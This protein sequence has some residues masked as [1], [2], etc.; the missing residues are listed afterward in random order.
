MIEF[1]ASLVFQKYDCICKGHLIASD[2][3][4]VEVKDK[5]FLGS[6]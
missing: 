4:F 6:Q 3:T 5:V 1:I 2:I